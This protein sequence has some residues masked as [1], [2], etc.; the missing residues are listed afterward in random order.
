VRREVKRSEARIRKERGGMMRWNRLLKIVLK[1][2]MLKILKRIIFV[3][4]N[5]TNNTMRNMTVKNT[6]IKKKEKTKRKENWKIL[7]FSQN[8][9]NNNRN[10]IKKIQMITLLM[11]FNEVHHQRILN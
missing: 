4:N 10:C 9:N 2:H 6:V 7:N 3:I 8:M 11:S 1:K 5:C